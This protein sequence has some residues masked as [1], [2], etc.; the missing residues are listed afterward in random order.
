MNGVEVVVGAG[1]ARWT[2]WAAPPPFSATRWRDRIFALLAASV[3]AALMLPVKP[4][5]ALAVLVLVV[6]GEATDWAVSRRTVVFLFLAS[7]LMFSANYRLKGPWP[8]DMTADRIALFLVLGAWAM[9]KLDVRPVW[10]SETRA[11]NTPLGALFA[12]TVVT[13]LVDGP[14]LASESL[15]MTG[16]KRMLV[17]VMFILVYS[18]V[19]ALVRTR[20]EV[21]GV[22]RMLVSIGAAAA[23]FG[24]IERVSR[25]NLLLRLQ[26]MGP[27]VPYRSMDVIVRGG[28]ARI[29]GTAAHPIEFG[30]VMALLLPLAIFVLFSAKG[31]RETALAGAAT[32]LIGAAML[33]T[34]S[35]SALIAS[36]VAFCL[37]MLLSRRSWSIVVA[38]L[39]ILLVVRLAFPGL[40]STFRSMLDPSWI[41]QTEAVSYSGRM[42]DWPLAWM[43]VRNNPLIGVGLGLFDPLR[44]FYVDNQFL[45]FLLEIGAF[46]LLVV[47]WFFGVV[48][49]SL[50]RGASKKLGN[51]RVP[52]EA[53]V[54]ASVTVYVVLS[55]LFDTFAFT[56]ITN[57]LF[58]LVGLAAV[59]ATPE[60]R[61]EGVGEW[62]PAS[63]S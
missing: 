12:V 4:S 24:I 52:L 63:T 14:R 8:L 38:A 59:L 57:L 15:V 13:L 54:L 46:G 29:Y 60:G 62:A 58:V 21:V 20:R 6:A 30:G 10:P 33:L 39:G 51:E 48:L 45:S 23:A 61:A 18:A 40:L 50:Y 41:V 56:Q 28:G 43:Y 26:S 31:P 32:G 2:E 5:V 1:A 25:S 36:A 35:R 53:A 42:N 17:L 22:V 7:I 37:L 19:V 47:L 11:F 34:V 27:F 9:R 55:A 44:Y 3:L 49:R 16:V